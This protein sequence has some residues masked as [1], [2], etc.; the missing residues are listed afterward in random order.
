[1][2]GSARAAIPIELGSP[3]A[4]PTKQGVVRH[5]AAGPSPAAH[6]PRRVSFG[7]LNPPDSAAQ[8]AASGHERWPHQGATLA[9]AGAERTHG[10]RD[11][12]IFLALLGILAAVTLGSRALIR[13]SEGEAVEAD[14]IEQAFEPPPCE[15]QF[16]EG[17]RVCS[18]CCCNRTSPA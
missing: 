7:P 9:V 2:D 4:S 12:V 18:E 3:V 16:A 5:G 15:A 10:R 1:V 11:L 17:L 14:L 8:G 13:F 6:E